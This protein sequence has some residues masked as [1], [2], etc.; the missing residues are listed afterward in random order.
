LAPF[1]DRPASGICSIR[2]SDFIDTDGIDLAKFSPTQTPVDNMF[3]GLEKL[4]PKNAEDRPRLR[5]QYQC[6][7]F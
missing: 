1:W 4:F 5:Q 2:V 3:D 7:G 6:P